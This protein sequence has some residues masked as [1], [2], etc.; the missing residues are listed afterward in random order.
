MTIQSV[1]EDIQEEIFDDGT[2]SNF[3]ELDSEK[4]SFNS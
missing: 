1:K 2:V 3:I 4:A